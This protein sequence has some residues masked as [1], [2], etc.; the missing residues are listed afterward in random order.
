[1]NTTQQPIIEH[2]SVTIPASIIEH[3]DSIKLDNY[4]TNT[5]KTF[6]KVSKITQDGLS[7]MDELAKLVDVPADKLDYVYFSVCKG[8]VEHVDE[9]PEG[10]F[11]DTTFVIPVIL[12]EGKSIIT[13]LDAQAE[14]FIG[15]VY[16]FDHTKRHSMILEDNESG[17]TV[18]MV[19]ILQ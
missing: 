2:G 19:A 12:P 5:P 15:K 6:Q 3:A 8:A 11:T 16:E 17:C 4:K 9:L 13:A 14:V 18:L 1:M 10:K 7:L